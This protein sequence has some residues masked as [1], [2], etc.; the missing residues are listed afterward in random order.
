MLILP[1]ISISNLYFWRSTGL[2]WR[3]FLIFS[4]RILKKCLLS[5][6]GFFATI[7]FTF[8][9]VRSSFL[10][11]VYFK[12]VNYVKLICSNMSSRSLT[13]DRQV[14]RLIPL[15][16]PLWSRYLRPFFSM[17]QLIKM[18]TSTL[19]TMLIRWDSR[20]YSSLTMNT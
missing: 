17:S 19:K 13:L 20:A 15:R 11:W 2:L 16:M 3:F 7:S 12:A 5:F 4:L 18:S 14:A 9:W 1:F 10:R 8:P 6:V